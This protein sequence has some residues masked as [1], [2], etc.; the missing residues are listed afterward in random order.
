[1]ARLLLSRKKKYLEQ[2]KTGCP[3]GMSEAA[4]TVMEYMERYYGGLVV[5]GAEYLKE[6]A[7]EERKR[8]LEEIPVLPYSIIVKKDYNTVVSDARLKQLDLGDYAVPIISLEAIN[9][10]KTLLDNRSMMFVMGDGDLFVDEKL[11]FM[12]KIEKA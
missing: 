6:L 2:L 3:V 9:S 5:Y 12:D 8:I 1:M 10:K 11:N 7:I 4:S